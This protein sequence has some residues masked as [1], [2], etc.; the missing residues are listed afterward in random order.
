MR[1][2]TFTKMLESGEDIED[3][4]AQVKAQ[5]DNWKPPFQHRPEEK[6]S[7]RKS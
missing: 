6:C 3:L 4:R 7:A 2:K 5:A 1:K